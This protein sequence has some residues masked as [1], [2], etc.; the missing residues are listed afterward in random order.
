M[1]IRMLISWLLCAMISQT[2]CV[3]LPIPTREGK[4]L[5]GKPVTQEQLAF[6]VPN[7]TTKKEVIQHVGS[8]N[9]IWEEANVFAYDWV[10][11]Q[12]V[13]IWAVGGGAGPA[14]AAAGVSDI[15]KRYKLLIQFDGQ[16]RVRRFETVVWPT[17]MSYGD[18]LKEWVRDSDKSSPQGLNH[19][20]VGSPCFHIVVGW[21]AV[22][23]P[24]SG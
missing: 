4:V 7:V 23:S 22:H 11:R 5:A 21:T 13:L 12:G 17:H 24:N 9:V 8:P 20:G 16:D 3:M 2:G 6:L 19:K 1:R 15:P 14:S 18:F 10:V